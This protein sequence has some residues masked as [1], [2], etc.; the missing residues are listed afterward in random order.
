MDKD[1]SQERSFGAFELERSALQQHFDSRYVTVSHS[2]LRRARATIDSVQDRL[3]AI[4]PMAEW[5]P[6]MAPTVRQ[7]ASYL[8]GL[9]PAHQVIF[10]D[11]GSSAENADAARAGRAT[12]IPQ[13]D[14][15][16]AI[17]WTRLT[18]ILNRKGRPH[19]RAGQGLNVLAGH[20]ALLALG[21]EPDDLVFQCDAD[22]GGYQQLAPLERLVHAWSSQEGV[23]HAKLAKFGR[24]NE[25]LMIVRALQQL[26]DVLD[27]DWIPPAVKDAG[28]DVFLALAPDKWLTCGLYLSLGEVI[29]ARP[30]AS[31]YLDAATQ[32]LWTIGAP[33]CGWRR[34]RHVEAPPPCQDS[35]N[36]WPKECVMMTTIAMFMQGVVLSGSLPHQWTLS[37]IGELN[38]RLMPALGCVPL[39]GE[40]DGPVSISQVTT[41]RILPSVRTLL[42]NGLLDLSRAAQVAR[43]ARWGTK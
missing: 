15:L 5:Q 4:V 6:E 33:E 40:A 24:N 17:D 11:G 27:V 32:A 3:W 43:R 23:Q 26:W 2:E 31:G 19:G 10:M 21:A 29:Q 18:P 34:V 16:D 12:V 39:I 1:A 14:I 42:D 28:N 7:T 30:G 35:V 38:Q 25:S 36:S 22:V 20:I 9:M 13:D 8:C 41:E 37:D